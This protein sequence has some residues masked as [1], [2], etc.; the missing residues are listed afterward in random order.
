MNMVIV[1]SSWEHGHGHGNMVHGNMVMV[2][3]MVSLEYGQIHD[4]GTCH[5]VRAHSWSWCHTGI[6]VAMSTWIADRVDDRHVACCQVVWSAMVNVGIYFGLIET[7]IKEIDKEATVILT[8]ECC[9]C[10]IN[11][12]QELGTKHDD[13]LLRAA[14][15]R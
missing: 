10:T 9:V 14:Q 7:T 11:I 1:T 3:V 8:R 5:T 6:V 12:V 2:M 13:R 4:R 15:W